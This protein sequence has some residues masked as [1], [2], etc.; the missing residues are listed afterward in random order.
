M[1]VTTGNTYETT[2]D[3]IAAIG[4]IFGGHESRF[5]SF[6]ECTLDKTVT[7]RTTIEE[8]ERG[9]SIIIAGI[10]VI[11]FFGRTQYSIT[12]DGSAG[13]LR[14]SDE[15]TAAIA[16]R[17]ADATGACITTLAPLTDLRRIA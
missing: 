1:A 8:T 2:G 10:A 14:L 9:T 17:C 6:V 13:D 15:R 11:T 3:G 16:I 12:T 7:T 5:T 4:E